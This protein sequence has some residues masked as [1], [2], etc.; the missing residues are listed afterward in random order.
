MY[1]SEHTISSEL[2]DK[3]RDTIRV[4]RFKHNRHISPENLDV[5]IQC[6]HC[7]W[8]PINAKA[9]RPYLQKK[10][11]EHLLFDRVK[12]GLKGATTTAD[13]DTI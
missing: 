11:Y 5:I 1:A 7:W 13:K 2:K 8:N 12:Q 9:L 10:G 6:T 4:N 3:I